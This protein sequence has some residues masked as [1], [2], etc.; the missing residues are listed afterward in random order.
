MKTG[1]MNMK[2]NMAMRISDNEIRDSC[3]S[4]Q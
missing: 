2:M 4:A 1:Q 3:Q